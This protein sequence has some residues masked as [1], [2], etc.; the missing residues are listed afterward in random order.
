MI[1]SAYSSNFYL[2]VELL[3]HLGHN[4]AFML[5]DVMKIS[6]KEA[7]LLDRSGIRMVREV[8]GKALRHTF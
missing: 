4:T 8:E 1:V 3:S 7:S 5:M 6:W 2:M